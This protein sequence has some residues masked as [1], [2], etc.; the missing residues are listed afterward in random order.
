[1]VAGAISVR[2]V[3]GARELDI[4][5]KFPWRIYKGDP[6]WVP[7]LL[8]EQ[9]GLLDTKK[10]PFYEHAEIQHYLAW[11]GGEIV[12]RISAILDHHYNDFHDEKTGFFG[13]FESIDDREVS[14]T[15][16]SA[17]EGWVQD[18]GMNRL[19]GPTNPGTNHVCALLVDGFDRPPVIQ[20][21]YNPRYYLDLY[22]DYGLG[23]A[24]DLYA[25]WMEDI[26]PVSDKIKRVAELVRSRQKVTIRSIDMKRLKEEIQLVKEVYND[27]WERNWGFVPWTDA[28]IQAVGQDLKMVVDPDLVMLAHVDGELAGF[29]LAL[30]DVNQALIRING[31]LFPFGLIK[32]LIYSKKIN[33]IRV[34]ALGIK[35]KFQNLGLDALFYYETYT[36]GTAHGFHAGEFSWVLENNAPMRNAMENWGA[37]IYKTYRMYQ[38]K[39]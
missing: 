8:A 17:A 11:K 27:A 9:K 13:F 4:F 19:M 1:L 36:R 29:S 6:N 30:P 25:Y 37:R 38:K 12:G 5:I 7:P 33:Q 18:K 15:L 39:L 28:E 3:A 35:K 20:M 21:P 23:K 24:R 10:N 32:L 22:T 2:P 14:R 16:F 31:R 34:L 26:T